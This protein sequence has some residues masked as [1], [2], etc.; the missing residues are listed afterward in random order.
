LSKIPQH[1]LDKASGND[2][3]IDLQQQQHRSLLHTGSS[4]AAAET[5]SKSPE[6]RLYTVRATQT[7]RNNILMNTLSRR[8]SHHGGGGA[9]SIE[10]D[11]QEVS[12]FTVFLLING[13]VRLFFNHVFWK[14]LLTK[15]AINSHFSFFGLIKAY[16]VRLLESVRLLEEIR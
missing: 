3:F 1:S 10:I 13:H 16:P 8:R 4:A 12:G 14:T 2:N 7:D 9:G 15:N 5:A 6:H 11:N